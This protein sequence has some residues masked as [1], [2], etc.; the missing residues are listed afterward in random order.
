MQATSI[1]SGYFVF[2]LMPSLRCRLN[3]PHCYLSKEQRDDPTV[4]PLDD[5]EEACRRIAAW[6]AGRNLPKKIV[7]GYWYGGEPTS[8]GQDYLVEACARMERVFRPE[9]GYELRQSVLSSL[10]AVEDPTWWPVIGRLCQGMVQTSY[11]GL[12]RGK[13]YVRR[14]EDKVREVQAAGLRVSTI[15]VVNSHLLEDGPEATLDRLSDLGVSE[16]SW[17]PFMQN[18]QNDGE[19]YETLAPGMAAW[20]DFMIRLTKRW[21]ERRDAGLFVPEIGQMR[22]VLSQAEAGGL[23]NIAGQTLFLLPDG[24]LTLPDYKDGWKEFMQPFGNILRQDFGSILA[25]KERRAYL[26]RQVLRNGNPECRD[27]PHGDK[28]VMEF[29]KPNRPGDDCFG[30]RRYVEWILENADSLIPEARRRGQSLY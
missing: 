28:C 26:R 30:G 21:R 20:S 23:A 2:T 11:D 4:M 24:T 10:V 6:Y 8:M 29:W 3:C 18:E 27:C 7:Q 16:T 13:G 19:K 25:S 12:M 5:L 22:F 1:E 9:D 14:W 15:S 17:L